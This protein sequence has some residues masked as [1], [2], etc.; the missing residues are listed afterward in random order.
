MK[1]RTVAKGK[2]IFLGITSPKRKISMLRIG[3]DIVA[4][5]SPKWEIK[6]LVP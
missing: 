1:D 6:S 3:A 5:F 4:P 2:T